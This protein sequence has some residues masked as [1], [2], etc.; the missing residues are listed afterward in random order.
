MQETLTWVAEL[1]QGMLATAIDNVGDNIMRVEHLGEP[2]RYVVVD[3]DTK[4]IAAWFVG[5]G[6]FISILRSW[7]LIIEPVDQ[8]NIRPLYQVAQRWMVQ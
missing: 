1:L 8:V 3:M 4:S 5:P 2:A 6:D 7:R